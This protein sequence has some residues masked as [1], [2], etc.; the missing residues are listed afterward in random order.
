[1]AAPGEESLDHMERPREEVPVEATPVEPPVRD[2]PGEARPSAP[3]PPAGAPAPPREAERDRVPEV[4]RDRIRA[5]VEMVLDAP[6]ERL[7]ERA[8]L[9]DVV[10]RV[11]IPFN[12][13]PNLGAYQDFHNASRAG[14][15]QVPGEYVDFLLMLRN[16]RIHSFCEIGTDRGGFAVLTCAYLMRACGLE[17]YHVVDV[18]DVFHDRAHFAARLPITFH[19]PATSDD[20]AGHP[21]D[22]VFID[23]D[24]SYGWA[25][26][27]FLNL[28]RHARL[29]CFHDIKGHEYDGM[30]G[31]IVRFW[32]EIKQSY[33]RRCSILEISHAA[34]A[35]MGIGLL[36]LDERL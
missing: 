16:R 25:K 1:M 17:E 18:A 29:C 32:G 12:D 3:P 7:G 14:L 5:A 8:F 30:G 20:L 13:W 33:S 28:G 2:A 4:E 34:P 11:G 15:I 24:H 6:P 9:M 10:R 26:R 21:F 27:D 36:F 22:V 19:I 23:G 35:W 31:G